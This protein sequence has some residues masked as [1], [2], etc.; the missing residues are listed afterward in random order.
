MFIG[1]LK[2]ESVGVVERVLRWVGEGQNERL[3]QVVT[4]AVNREGEEV[5]NY[6]NPPTLGLTTGEICSRLMFR[7]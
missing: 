4:R 5:C 6:V 1:G 2:T 3:L 7:C